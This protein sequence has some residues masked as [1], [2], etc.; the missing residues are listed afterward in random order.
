VTGTPDEYA[1][2][3]T[4]DY[5]SNALYAAG[6][7]DEY[8]STIRLTDAVGPMG[9][10]YPPSSATAPP[11]SYPLPRR[12]SENTQVHGQ[13]Q[14]RRTPNRSQTQLSGS[15]AG[16]YDY[17]AGPGYPPTAA[18]MPMPTS[19]PVS[20]HP[21]RQQSRSQVQ[22]HTGMASPYRTSPPYPSYPT[23]AQQ[24][25]TTSTAHLAAPSG[26]GYGPTGY[27]G[28]YARSA[29]PT[30]Y[31]HY[32]QARSQPQPRQ[33]QPPHRQLTDGYDNGQQ[34]IQHQQQHY[35]YPGESSPSPG[36]AYDQPDND[37]ASVDGH[38]PAPSYHTASPPRQDQRG[39]LGR[40]H[41]Y[42]DVHGWR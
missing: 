18:P 38:D 15:S 23:P 10:S 8:G 5:S 26:I 4:L 37:Y 14:G 3:P 21:M 30:S 24:A 29:S 6:S 17:S 32:D 34:H 25:P 41:G 1:Y 36:L 42:G 12:G 35:T 31:D 40:G 39:M 9:I 7:R 16:G 19:T 13:A 11:S 27:T 33:V 20:V 28:D 22:D 2:P